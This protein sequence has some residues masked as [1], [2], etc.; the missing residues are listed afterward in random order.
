MHVIAHD[1][2]LD[3]HSQKEEFLIQHV[4]SALF[5]TEGRIR[6]ALTPPTKFTLALKQKARGRASRLTA[7]LHQFF[8][9]FSLSVNV[10][11]FTADKQ[12]IKRSQ[13]QVGVN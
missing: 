4:F 13:R 11:A 7:A 9:S 5:M 10:L 1:S 6:S 3:L 8:V 12:D 2:S